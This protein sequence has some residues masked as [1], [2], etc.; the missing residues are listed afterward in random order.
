MFP[1]NYSSNQLPYRIELSQ[2]ISKIQNLGGVGTVTTAKLKDAAFGSIGCVELKLSQ[3]SLS[4]KSKARYAY[5]CMLCEQ[6]LAISTLRIDPRKIILVLDDTCPGCGSSLRKVLRCEALKIATETSLLVNPKIGNP[7][8]LIT[9]PDQEAG[10]SLTTAYALLADPKPYLATGM[11]ALDTALGLRLG[12]FAVLDE[13]AS[14]SISSLLC[15]RAVLPK[16]LGLDSDV[17]FLDGGNTFDAYS[18]SEQ[19]I[20]HEIESEKVLERIHLSRAFTYHQL[21]TLINEK[22]P[23][24]LDRFRARLAVVSDTTQLYCDPDV[25][26]KQEALDVFRKDVRALAILA[27]QKSTLIVATNLR[28]INKRMDSILLHTAHICAKLDRNTFT[29]L[30]LARHPLTP[31]LTATISSDNQTMESYL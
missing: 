1:V 18:I 2:E 26:S 29:Q 7:E 3:L 21:S 20:N 22:L 13:K 31:Q 9:R 10:F 17:V 16:P 14:H 19:A 25:Q 28:A 4:E 30:T 5:Y 8:C 6:V 24:A 11:E 27:K 12:Q 15:V 23:Q